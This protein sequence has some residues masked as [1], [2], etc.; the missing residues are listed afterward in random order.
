MT[1]VR[2]RCVWLVALLAL[3]AG[4]PAR[5]DETPPPAVFPAESKGA[6]AGVEDVRKRIADKQW[7]AAVEAIQA[8]MTASGDDLVPIG[9]DRSVGCRRLC[10]ALLASLPADALRSYRDG[11]D[12]QAK[13]MLD[14][15]AGRRDV[16]LLRKV[17]DEALCSRPSEKAID[18][19]GDLAF[20]R[21]DFAEAEQWWNL[22]SP[23]PAAKKASPTAFLLYY[24]DPQI[25]PARTRAKLLAARLFRGA[26]GVADDVETYRKEFGTAEGALAGKQG[27]YADILRQVAE[28]R[29][30]DPPAPFSTWPTFGGDA[31]RGRIAAAPPRLLEQLGALCRPANERRYSLKD[32]EPQ[33]MDPVYDRG[34]GATLANRSMAFEPVIADGKA[35]VADAQYVTAVDLRTGAVEH[36]YD[37]AQLNTGLAP[38][39]NLPAPPDL[40]YSLTA[41]GDR[42]F[43]RLG[44]QSVRDAA[45]VDKDAKDR[46]SL[47]VCLCLKPQADGTHKLWTLLAS[48]LANAD[49]DKAPPIFEGAPLVHDGLLYIASTRFMNGRPVTRIQCFP[50]DAAQAPEELWHQDICETREFAEKDRRFRQHLLTLAGPNVVYCS[51]SGAI[52]AL[53][54]VS[55]KPVWS[56]RYPSRGDKTAD[57]EPSPRDLAPCLFADGRLYIAPADY[58]RLL[59]LDPATG[60]K[61]WDRGPLEAVHLLGVGQGRLIF[62]T[63]TGLRAV[64]ADDGVDAWALP[65]GGGGLPPAGRGLLIGDVVLWPTAS[66]G[67]GSCE[68]YAVRQRDGQQPDDP[69]LL[70]HIPAGNLVYTDGCLLSADRQTLTLFTPPAVRAAE[71]DQAAPAEPVSPAK[72]K[73]Q[74]EERR[75][76][77]HAAL[78]EAARRAVT[79]RHWQEAADDFTAASSADFSAP[80]R[81]QTLLDAAALWKKAGQ[82]S[83]AVAAWQTVRT[84][85]AYRGLMV[86]DAWGVPQSAADFAAVRLGQA[87]K[88]VDDRNQPADAGR[89]SGAEPPF[90][91]TWE[92]T[93]DPGE[94]GLAVAGDLLLC[95]RGLPT[96]RL[97]ARSADSGKLR[98]QTALPFAP[99]WADRLGDVIVTAGAQGA[100]GLYAADGQVAWQFTA[101]PPS[102]TFADEAGLVLTPDAGRA[103][104][105]GNFLLIGG[106]FCLVQ[107]ERRIITLDAA[108]GHVLW[109]RRAVGAGL[110]LPYP[111]GRFLHVV[112]VGD[113]LLL[114]QTSGGR[115]WLMDAATGRL[116]H[117]DPAAREP[118]P[119][120]PILLADGRMLLT[121]DARTV[122]LLDPAA[123]RIVWTHTL[124]GITTRTG[125]APRLSAGPAALLL[126]WPTNVGWRVQRLD[127][128]TGQP[129]WPDPPLLNIDDLDVA[130]W[131]QDGGAFYGVRDGVLFARSLMDGAVLWERSAD[132]PRGRW[133]TQR[134]GG[135]LVAYPD[136]IRGAQFQ[137]RWLWR[138]LQWEGRLPLEAESGRGFPVACYDARTG[139]LV[140]RLNFPIAAESLA[141]WGADDGCLWPAC[142]ME[143]VD[144]RPLVRL[145]S[146]RLVVALAG[147]AWGLAAK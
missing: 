65:D 93:L 129:V 33:D 40:R 118:W 96:G 49:A 34:V 123:D 25:D 57:G 55:G 144:G 111:D 143:S 14:Q 76:E 126:A 114:V 142:A 140:Q 110:R 27:R 91:R 120:T 134:V 41:A 130:G 94:N 70:R 127:R 2:K 60:E 145:A 99:T 61:L 108:S 44:T 122:A 6:A 97:T 63:P 137:C 75:R 1:G 125:E 39:R 102:R 115:R 90:F 83:R 128:A 101:P 113:A 43:A 35:I 139:R 119:R 56:V 46:E 92:A 13:K 131:S 3:A 117:D 58:D 16:R 79:A 24:P 67:P 15:A 138:R 32:R 124:P 17:V 18:L 71:R 64:G 141:R 51:H 30:A 103:D 7:A 135:S 4:G 42:I 45:S 85:E 5:G 107:G 136:Q 62:T 47:L 12:P 146:G 74:E 72:R 106:C 59:C 86:E 84:G 121:P 116:L 52:A 48:S 109:A 22:L 88:P 53:D 31:S 66:K 9:P 20:E 21:G 54:A 100:A 105:L 50:A 87:A 10:Q 37:A 82:D 26:Y 69:S 23:P 78:M 73:R 28:E 11:A 132:G 81:L 68:V 147:K 98:W 80:V 77:K 8:V 95:G 104:P 89:S 112:P 133:R 36:W 19:L 29:D 38:N